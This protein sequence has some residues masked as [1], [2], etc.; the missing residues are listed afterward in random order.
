M[1]NFTIETVQ[2]YKGGY[3]INNALTITNGEGAAAEIWAD[4]QVWLLTNTPDPE[5]NPIVVNDNP[6]VDDVYDDLLLTNRIVKALIEALNDG[7]FVPG[8]NYTNQQIKNGL[9]NRL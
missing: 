9:K 5:V 1:S 8:S 3:L 7:T 4:L 6:T 2:I